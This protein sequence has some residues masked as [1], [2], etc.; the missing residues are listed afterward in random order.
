MAVK[1]KR[2]DTT[3]TSAAKPRLGRYRLLSSIH[4]VGSG[5]DAKVYKKG[6][7]VHSETDLRREFP[8]KFEKIRDDVDIDEDEQN[9]A[10][11][12]LPEGVDVTEMFPH[13]EEAGLLVFK[14]K[15]QYAVIDK[16]MPG[17]SLNTES[18]INK[19]QVERFLRDY[20]TQ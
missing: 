4:E 18:L 9:A 11:D 15:T 20:L 12:G 7:I 19:Q 8:N 2:R 10:S 16:G 14:N 6:A 5:K 13:A 17:K 1:L 3:T